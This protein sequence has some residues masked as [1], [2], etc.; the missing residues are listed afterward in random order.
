MTY[1]FSASNTADIKES[2]TWANIIKYCIQMA[3]ANPTLVV[4]IKD[5]S[6]PSGLKVMESFIWCKESNDIV[7]SY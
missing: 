5:N 3:K 7:P 2:N 4:R 6:M 1:R